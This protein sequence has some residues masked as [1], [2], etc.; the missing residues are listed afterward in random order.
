MYKSALFLIALLSLPS[1]A[2]KAA[3][4]T[5]EDT[6]EQSE[7]VRA[8]D[9]TL[10]ESFAK[11][12]PDF[13]SY[14]F[15]GLAELSRYELKQSRYGEIH[16]GEAVNVFVT[17][18]FLT[19]KQV[20]HEFGE[21]E[22]V[23]VLK[24]NHYRRFYTG[25]YPYTIMT[26]TFVPAL[27]EGS[28]IKLT[29]TVQEWCGQVFAQLNS[30]DEGG[31]DAK[32]FSY[33]QAEGDQEFQIGDVVLEDDLMT[34]VRKG[35]DALPTGEFQAVPAF[36]YL[37]LMHKPVQAYDASAT[38]SEP[39]KSEFSDE[40]LRVYTVQWT[41]PQRRLEI[42]FKPSHPYTIEG[43]REVYPGL[44]RQEHTTVAKRT[45]SIMLDY[46][47]KHSNEHAPYRDA[48]GLEF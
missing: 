39:Q 29:T 48:L 23:Q 8:V 44:D 43:W 46:W 17:E 11:S 1:C 32:S 20:K 22:D 38:L 21:G 19:G 4:T 35:P 47:S 45:K 34:K 28:T 27:Q 3:E 24:L 2:D 30:R 42:H 41:E 26:S 36:H 33:F 18:P 7:K 31:W 40:E 12:K 6:R 9:V 13:R 14:W 37:R 16:E 25:I 10:S 15:A 5:R